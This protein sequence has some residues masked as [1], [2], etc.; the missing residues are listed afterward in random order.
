MQHRINTLFGKSK[1]LQAVIAAALALTALVAACGGGEPEDLTFNL[2]IRDGALVGENT[3]MQ[4]R[5]GD[6][7]TIELT[8]DAVVN[9]HLHGYDLEGIVEPENPA[10]IA[11]EAYAT[12]NFPFTAHVGGAGHDHGSNEELCEAEIAQGEPE[13]EISVSAGPSSEPH[14]VDVSV[15]T[16]NVDLAPDG[17]HWH[18][19]VNGQS[20]GMY[21]NPRVTFDTRLY[22]GS[23]E[24]EIMV[25]IND[26]QHCDY[27]VRAMTTV[28]MDGGQSMSMDHAG[29]MADSGSQNEEE[30]ELGRL[31]VQPR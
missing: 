16:R 8:S 26:A 21:A 30:I 31:V 9:Y 4:A 5:Q 14:L 12:G 6:S 19:A 2:V 22:E 24:Y 11:F 3:T 15:E 1:R 20:V 27:G 7:I 23:G 28:A 10:T 17:D 18:L 25:S 13:P 29:D